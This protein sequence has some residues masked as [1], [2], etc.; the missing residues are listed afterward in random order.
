VPVTVLTGLP[1]A[2]KATLPNRILIE[3]HGRPIAVIESEARPA[4]PEK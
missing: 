1:G 3:E 2:G 4:G